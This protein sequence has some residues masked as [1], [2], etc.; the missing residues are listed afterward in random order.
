[1]ALIAW[2]P[3]VFSTT[4]SD[5]DQGDT[6]VGA[7][8]GFDIYP[9]TDRS[10]VSELTGTTLDGDSFALSDLQGNTVVLNAP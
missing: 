7:E 9:V 8:P 1:M 10:P 5:A 6:V 4:S 2:Q 3:G